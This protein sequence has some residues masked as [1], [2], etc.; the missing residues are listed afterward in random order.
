MPK[1]LKSFN[2]LIRDIKHGRK[3]QE[4]LACE[5]LEKID[6]L[7]KLFSEVPNLYLYIM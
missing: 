3:R 2:T 4:Q 6:A 1:E 5:K 7:I